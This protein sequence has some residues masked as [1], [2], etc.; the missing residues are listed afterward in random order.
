M[1]YFYAMPFIVGDD[2]ILYEAAKPLEFEGKSYPGILISYE[3]GVG[4]SPEDQYIVYYDEDTG[5]MQWLGYTVT[6]G[7]NEKSKNFHYIRYN[8]WQNTNGLMLPKSIDW[9]KYENNSLTE[10]R[11]T[12]EFIDVVISEKEPDASLFEK[13]EDATI[14]E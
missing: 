12:V 5:L 9:Y 8:N 1:L 14:I 4:V 6:F 11:N 7:K 13:P 2:G 10:K 3:A